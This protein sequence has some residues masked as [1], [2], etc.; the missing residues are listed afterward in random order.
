MIGSPRP[1]DP[2]HRQLLLAVSRGR[3]V[4]A[5]GDEQ[6]WSPRRARQTMRRLRADLSASTNLH[7]V[8]IAVRRGQI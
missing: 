6:G 2:A 7:A 8:C 1:L 4:A 5:A 3:T